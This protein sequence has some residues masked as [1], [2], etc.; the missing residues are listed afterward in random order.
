MTVNRKPTGMAVS[1]PVGMVWGTMAAVAVTL[2]GAGLTAKLIDSQ[3]L[4]WNSS[5]YAV[6]LILVLSAWAGAMVAAGRIKRQRMMVCLLSG[7]M[8]FGVLMLT[9]ALFF[10]GRYSG[11]GETGLLILCGS[12]L[13]VFTGYKGKTGRKTVKRGYRNR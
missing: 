1:I 3:M 5:G 6:L 4:D 10:G 7:V 11:V 13:G 2:A 8:Y 9:T 12:M